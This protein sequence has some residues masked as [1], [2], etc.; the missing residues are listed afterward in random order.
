M[1][2]R[3]SYR[4]LGRSVA[5]WL[6]PGRKPRVR[7]PQVRLGVERLEDRCVPAGPITYHQ[8]EVLTNVQ[9]QPVFLGSDWSSSSANQQDAQAVTQYLQYLTNS[10]YM[11]MLGEYY[12][13]VSNQDNSYK[14]PVG[15]GSVVAP[16]YTNDSLPHISQGLGI[17]DSMPTTGPTTGA[18]NGLE[19]YLAQQIQ[20]GNA[21]RPSFS[22]VG[23]EE[24]LYMVFLPPGVTTTTFYNTQQDANGNPVYTL[25]YHN[26]FDLPVNVNGL[27]AV[28]PVV[29]AVIP[30]P[31][32]NTSI[33]G[34]P[35]A[36][37]FQTADAS[38]ELAEA[39]TDPYDF[40]WS[41]F[42][43]DD[44]GWFQP[45]P[46]GITVKGGTE[47]GDLATGYYLQLNGYVVQAEWSASQNAIVGPLGATWL[48]TGS[49]NNGTGLSL[50]NDGNPSGPLASAQSYQ[51]TSNST[52]TVP[53]STGLL[54]NASDPFGN[55]LQAVLLTPPADGSVQLNPDGSFTYTPNASFSGVDTFT[56]AASDG[57]FESPAAPVSI[58]VGTPPALSGLS[59]GTA[60][61]GSADF[62]LTLT[63]NNFDSTA[64]VLWDGTPL[65][66]QFDSASQ[67]E[68][69][70]PAGLLAEEGSPIVS[71]T[72]D[73]GTTG[74]LPFTI[75]DAPLTG[76]HVNNPAATRGVGFSGFPVASFHDA[77]AGTSA[78]DF[79]A[80]V[81]W[82]DGTG[83]S[84]DV[85]ALGGG[86]FAV[87]AS[88]TYAEEGNYALSVQVLDAGG[89]SVD[90][91]TTIRVADAPMGNLSV[92]TPKATE[93]ANTGT[94]TVASF[95]DANAATPAADF[96][97]TVT[98]GDGKSS[99][100]SVR[101]LGGGS[102]AV[103]SSHTYAEEGKYTLSVKI[104]DAGGSSISG[105]STISV[106]DAPVGNLIVHSPK[107]TEGASTGTVTVASFR[108]ANAAAIAADFTATVT[109][110][111][112]STSAAR[113]VSQGGGNFAILASHTYAEEGTKNLSV[114]IFDGGAA[115]SGSIT[116]AVADAP[117]SS[118]SVHSPGAA[119]GVGTGPFTVAVFHDSNTAAQASDFTAAI[120]WGD[121]ST[122]TVSGGGIVAV[123]GGTF[124]VV[125]AHTYGTAGG[126]T[127]SVHLA[128]AGGSSVGGSTAAHAASPPAHPP[129]ASPPPPVSPPPPPS[130]STNES[131][132]LIDLLIELW[133]LEI[134]SGQ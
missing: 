82:G 69:L 48:T 101:A 86:N 45:G 11:D 55:P 103:V 28:L 60:A 73:A 58:Q 91:S 24:T 108:D 118:L 75:T 88:H 62:T 105:S 109:W 14:I 74:G 27:D 61:E 112:G 26:E 43:I 5:R 95:T 46:D 102:F 33:P 117:L 124:D 34:L 131:R 23:T 98:W 19:Q 127:L 29:Y 41:K 126:F 54:A 70:V 64:T 128:D 49:P 93:G 96:T 4:I 130:S 40:F 122:S 2:G 76:L 63:G 16:D 83:S 31:Q 79:T 32:G 9:V 3:W 17:N 81:G 90:G 66:T 42:A 133:F 119:A 123:G 85:V 114:K 36:F 65:A 56:Y 68:A 97:A 51:V 111:D 57:N 67:L 18:R 116:L 7:R 21:V 80:S 120:A 125:S 6:S 22:N 110:G 78:A 99:S 59:Q 50:E 87:L 15:R 30:Y 71:V 44:G 38:H 39:V 10:P 89:S 121:G 129:A 1:S 8:G 107:A 53:A 37:N 100:A 77:N 106:A 115:V 72:E 25:G 94:L 104:L 134:L 132:A 84:A 20:S 47:I 35:N 12:E 52:L 92:H 13:N 113:V